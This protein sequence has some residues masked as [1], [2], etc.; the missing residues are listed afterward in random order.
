MTSPQ[1]NIRNVYTL[2]NCQKIPFNLPLHAGI[3]TDLPARLFLVYFSVIHEEP[4]QVKWQYNLV[5]LR[6]NPRISESI[7]GNPYLQ[8]PE[9]KLTPAQELIFYKT[10]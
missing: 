8:Q 1:K 6:R 2:P 10:E 3:H 9:G 5:S 4:S 7:A